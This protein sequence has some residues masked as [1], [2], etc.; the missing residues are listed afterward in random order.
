MLEYFEENVA[1]Y[2][3]AVWCNYKGIY[4][5]PVRLG[6]PYQ[7]ELFKIAKVENDVVSFGDVIY[8]E[9]TTYEEGKPVLNV[10][11]TILKIYNELA[12]IK[13]N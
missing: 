5:L 9:Y 10:F 12:C 8:H 1:L 13:S 2:P 4:F 7:K 11:D 6:I 3:P